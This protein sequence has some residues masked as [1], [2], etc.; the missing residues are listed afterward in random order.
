MCGCSYSGNLPASLYDEWYLILERFVWFFWKAFI[1]NA[2]GNDN[3]NRMAIDDGI[4][5]WA[6]PSQLV[7]GIERNGKCDDY[8]N[9]EWM[10]RKERAWKEKKEFSKKKTQWR[11]FLFISYYGQSLISLT[12]VPFNKLT[13]KASGAQWRKTKWSIENKNFVAHSF[14]HAMREN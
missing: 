7:V 12:F 8:K 14:W 3:E 1:W 13:T 11:W 9:W 2:K 5:L 4:A 10:W 6:Q